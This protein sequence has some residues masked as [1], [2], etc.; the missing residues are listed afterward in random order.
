MLALTRKHNRGGVFL[1]KEKWETLSG[2]KIPLDFQEDGENASSENAG[3][4]PYT[5]G[6]HSTMYRSRLWTMRQYAGFSSA[7]Q[8]NERFKL[9]LDRGQKGL[10]V[11]FDLPTQLGMDSDDAMSAGEIGKVGVAIDSVA[12][13]QQLFADIPLDK[14]STSM[15][16]NSPAIILLAMYI[17][18]AEEQGV[19]QSEIRGTIQNDILKEYIARGTYV[20]PPSHSMRLI[21]DIFQYCTNSVPQWNTISISGYHIREAGSTAVQEVAYT[22]SN[23]L[24]YVKYAVNAGLEVDSFAPRLSFFFNCHNDFFEEI[25]KFRAA[26]KLWHD[27]MT[28]HFKPTNP[29]SSMLRFHTQVAGV[30]LTAQQPLNNIARVTIQALAAV[31]GGTQSLHTNSFDEALGLPTEKS[32]TVALRTQQVIAEESGAA[33]V[34]DPLGGSHH[35]EY[36]TEKI[37]SLARSEIEK[38]DSY[39]GALKAMEDGYQQRA[40]HDAAWEHL[41]QVESGERKI[42]GVNH[43]LM[44][45]G[46]GP[47]TLTLDPAI[48]QTQLD[49][50]ANLKKSRDMEKVKQC[51]A[52]VSSCANGE[53]NI[54]PL[55]IEAVRNNCTLGEV[56]NSMKE[57]FGTYRSPSGF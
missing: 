33:D 6:I 28:E 12:D 19:S 13:M 32:A 40:I 8:T 1:R 46:E 41:Q 30:S 3:Q 23:A 57:I 7:K 43:G 25:A 16:I 48:A 56:M 2:I 42:V 17:V 9:L 38:I 52:A 47:E 5:R 26:R 49:N 34:V 31:C 55:I 24:E 10:S 20:F 36:L 39:G 27:L 21:S 54:F 50:L 15:T 29:K 22:L 14:V 51:L 45:E 4:P 35:V 37:Y 11:A 18:V 44:D 53:E